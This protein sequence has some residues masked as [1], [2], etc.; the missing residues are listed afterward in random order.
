VL[1]FNTRGRKNITTTLILYFQKEL[2][3]KNWS[4][5]LEVSNFASYGV[6]VLPQLK[7]YMDL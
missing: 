4:Y 7:Q 2:T 1:A 5:I 3:L 6:L